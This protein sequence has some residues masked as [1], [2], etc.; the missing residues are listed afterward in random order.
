MHIRSK[1]GKT[2][3]FFKYEIIF[4][5]FQLIILDVTIVE[6]D[7]IHNNTSFVK[8][9]S[10]SV[11]LSLLYVRIVKVNVHTNFLMTSLPDKTQGALQ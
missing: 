2:K 6:I 4:T 1:Y 11:F 5:L 3:P 10:L 9:V 8:K 7:I